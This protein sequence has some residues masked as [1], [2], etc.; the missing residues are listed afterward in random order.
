MTAPVTAGTHVEE[1]GRSPW[2]RF[3]PPALGALVAAATAVGLS[4]GRDVAP[5]VLASGVVYLGAAVGGRRWLAWPVFGVTLAVV[6]AAKLADLDAVTW[7]LVA[8]GAMLVVG[9]ALRR[10]HPSWSFPLQAVAMLVLAA[11]ALLAVRAMPTAGGLIVAAAL[12]GHAA[13]DLHH[14]RTG[15]VVSRSLAEFCMVLDTLVAVVVA[16]VALTS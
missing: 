7:L 8:A 3:W 2:S 10:W 11:L 15:R 12:L 14:H 6:T 5:V 4:D 9:V 1:R 16:F 13:W